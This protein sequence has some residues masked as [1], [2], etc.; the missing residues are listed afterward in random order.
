LH[1][2]GK[3]A[4]TSADNRGFADL[5]S[6][7]FEPAEAPAVT[8]PISKDSNLKCVLIKQPNRHALLYRVEHVTAGPTAR[9]Y[10]EKLF[11]DSVKS[12]DPKSWAKNLHFKEQ[13]F[14]WN[15][16]GRDM[17]NQDNFNIRLFP[18]YVKPSDN[19]QAK[20]IH[21]ANEI[22]KYLN[23]D[24]QYGKTTVDPD[25]FFWLPENAVWSDV[26]GEDEAVNALFRETRTAEAYPGYFD[27]NKKTIFT[28]F[29][30]TEISKTLG[31]V[32]C[33]PNSAVSKVAAKPRQFT[34]DLGDDTTS[35]DD[36][37]P[38]ADQQDNQDDDDDDSFIDNT[39]NHDDAASEDYEQ[40]HDAEESE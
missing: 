39:N 33:A 21:L 31:E 38:S 4:A 13:P 1:T 15:H 28:Y 40:E 19:T 27:A 5:A 16:E 29:R 18:L 14:H 10:A 36:S 32:L 7:G 17:L 37:E 20:A 26:L 24:Q 34:I 22:C 3:P 12:Q 25:N 35:D 6:I 9:C 11:N 2:A 8:K 30:R 23:L